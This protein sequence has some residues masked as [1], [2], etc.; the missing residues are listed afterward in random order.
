[1]NQVLINCKSDVK[2]YIDYIGVEYTKTSDQYKVI[3][4]NIEEL[5]DEEFCEHYGIK[6][7]DV[8]CVELLN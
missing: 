8:N 5:D 2:N 1:M 3:V 7:D 4:N 6:Y